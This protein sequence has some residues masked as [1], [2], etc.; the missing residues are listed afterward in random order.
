MSSSRSPV[1]LLIGND[2]ALAYLI[3]R[4]A[5]RSGFEVRVH[6]IVPASLTGPDARPA[7]LLFSSIEDL[8][9]AQSQIAPLT[10]A[11]FPLL[12]C[13]SVNDQLRAREL[14]VDH[15]LVHP[16]TYEGFLA[17]LTTAHIP[18]H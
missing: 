8:E 15:C 2:A 17:A 12:V 18:L 14:G 6:S 7:A 13:S 1:I 9:A 3:E 10:S 11:E 4:Y 5:E 16:L